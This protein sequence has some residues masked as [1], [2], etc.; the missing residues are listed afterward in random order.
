MARPATLYINLNAIRHNYRLA[1]SLSQ[2]QGAVAIIKAN[3]YGHG[4]IQVAEA[5][6]AEADAFGVACIEEAIEL[7]DA[8]IKNP[9]LLLEGF[10]TKD[11][12]QYISRNNIWCAVHSTEQIEIIAA[13][14]L[15]VAINFWL[16]M[17][18]GM[19]RLGINP[20]E[21]KQAF[22]R[23]SSLKQTNSIVLMS[24]FAASDEPEKDCTQQ[25]IQ[26]FNSATTGLQAPISL[27]NSAAILSN[28][29]S[30]Q[31][32]QRP[33]IML[34]GASPFAANSA[35]S[36]SLKPAMSLKTGIIATRE[37]K[38][39]ETIGYGGTW[40][41][42]QPTK[43]ATIAIGYAD[44]YPRHAANGTP[45]LVNGKRTKIIGRVSMD[46]ITIDISHIPEANVGV[47][48]ELWGE[49]LLASEVAPYCGTIPYTL[50]TGITPR[51]KRSYLFR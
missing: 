9:I 8:G 51:V 30:H 5:L 24:H 38:T 33:G 32:W 23:L 43:I 16:K 48:V 28:S 14:N 10:F 13:E 41:C 35:I 25:Q 7:R 46:M 31:Q 2:N 49:N 26:C 40:T 11:E 20:A 15:P 44:G 39:G 50:F 22:T 27:A 6:T 36:T 4:A 47:E 12:L 42:E 21:F 19:H 17:D 1:K 29:T 45:V 18:S 34:Y 37:V 3:A